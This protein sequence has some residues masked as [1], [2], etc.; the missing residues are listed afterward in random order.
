MCGEFDRG[1]R[2]PSDIYIYIYAT[3]LRVN[4]SFVWLAYLEVGELVRPVEGSSL[5]QLVGP[6][7][8]LVVPQIDGAITF[9][10]NLVEKV[11]PTSC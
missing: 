6:L 2:V 5:Q 11:F 10:L 1:N 9:L 4:L 3:M 7:S 8:K